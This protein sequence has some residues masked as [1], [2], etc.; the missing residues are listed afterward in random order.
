MKI[1]AVGNVNADFL[2]ILGT[3]FGSLEL[4]IW[5]LESEKIITGSL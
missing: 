2:G 1:I 3:R 5:S 4:K